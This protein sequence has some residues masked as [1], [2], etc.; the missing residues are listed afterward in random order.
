M[1]SSAALYIAPYALDRVVVVKCRA[2]LSIIEMDF[3]WLE[4]WQ[5]YGVLLSP[6]NDNLAAPNFFDLTGFT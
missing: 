2:G 4:L 6:S 3:W 5:D 1:M